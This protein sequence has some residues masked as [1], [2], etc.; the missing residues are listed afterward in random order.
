MGLTVGAKSVSTGSLAVTLYPARTRFSVTSAPVRM[1]RKPAMPV[2]DRKV[3]A[4]VVVTGNAP[5]NFLLR[6]LLEN[7]MD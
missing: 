1:L 7:D 5:N 6:S 4:T 2:K 3:K